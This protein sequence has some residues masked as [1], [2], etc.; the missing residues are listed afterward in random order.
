MNKTIQLRTEIISILDLLPLE[1]IQLLAEFVA[2]LKAKF[3][4]HPQPLTSQEQNQRDLELLNR[5]A[6]RLNEEALDVLAY[7]IAI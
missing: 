2:F 5:H 4:I 6:Q 1:G 3:K 7:Q